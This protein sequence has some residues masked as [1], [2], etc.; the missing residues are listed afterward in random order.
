MSREV[1]L[2]THHVGSLCFNIF[3]VQQTDESFHT[4]KTATEAAHSSQRGASGWTFFTA[5]LREASG[6]KQ[7]ALLSEIDN[8]AVG[9]LTGHIIGK[10]C[11]VTAL[12]VEEKCRSLGIGAL[13]LACAQ[14]FEASTNETLVCVLPGQ[15][16]LKNLCEQA[17][18]PAQLIFAGTP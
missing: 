11:I 7:F 15:R 18:L 14:Q 13:L 17:G 6:N 4:I 9:Y 1:A 16:E 12:Y 3:E 5:L 10:R 8:I 2:A